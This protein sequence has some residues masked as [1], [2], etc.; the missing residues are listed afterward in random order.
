MTTTADGTKIEPR[1]RGR[2]EARTLK[3]SEAADL[4]SVSSTTLRTWEE[5]FGFPRP[6]RSSGGH[7]SYLFTEIVVLRD[8]MRRGLSAASAISAVASGRGADGSALVSALSSFDGAWAD[9]VMEGSLVLRSLEQSVEQI[10]IGALEDVER[11]HSAGSVTGTFAARWALGW[12]ARAERF[13]MPRPDAR[14]ILVGEPAVNETQASFAIVRALE[15]LCV[16]DGHVVTAVPVSATRG[17]AEAVRWLKPACLLVAGVDTME[18]RLARWLYLGR[19]DAGDAPVAW[20][21][22]RAGSR[23]GFRRDGVVLSTSVVAAH[24]QL[25]RLLS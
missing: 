8:A 15:L 9:R 25:Q 18:D 2:T 19:A 3:T 5:Q 12:L 24:D 21:R 20:F 10:L 6:T 23:A 4:L 1:P 17:L 22:C 14:V 16:L 7:R 11:R 13:A